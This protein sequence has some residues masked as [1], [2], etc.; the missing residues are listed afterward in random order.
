MCHITNCDPPDIGENAM[1]FGEY[2]MEIREIFC[3]D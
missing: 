2:S 1:F 3:Y